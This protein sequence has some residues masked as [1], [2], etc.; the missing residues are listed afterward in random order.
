MKYE[1]IKRTDRSCLLHKTFEAVLPNRLPFERM[2]LD[3]IDSKNREQRLKKTDFLN[4]WKDY[5]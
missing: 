2:S 3:T 5:H 4:Y 1:E